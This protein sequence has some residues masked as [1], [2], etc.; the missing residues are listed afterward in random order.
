[1]MFGVFSGYEM[2]LLKDWIA[3]DWQA[4]E[5]SNPFRTRFRRRHVGSNDA[6]QPRNASSLPFEK[7]VELIAPD[8]HPT[9]EG[10]AATRIYARQL[11]QGSLTR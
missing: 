6:P 9:P 3:G 5:Q 8:A 11:A 10:L 1:V 2:Q 4:S 7:L